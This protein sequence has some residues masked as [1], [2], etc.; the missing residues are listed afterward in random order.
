MTRNKIRIS[1]PH[2]A[3]LV[4]LFSVVALTG[5]DAHFIARWNANLDAPERSRR[6]L[7]RVSVVL[8]QILTAQ[9]RCYLSKNSFEICI[10]IGNERRAASGLRDCF[11][12]MLSP[13]RDLIQLDRRSTR[14]N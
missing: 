4:L 6:N 10:G 9:L 2:K 1:D 12:T 13:H 5:A 7:F 8:Q 14:I 11:H 3:W